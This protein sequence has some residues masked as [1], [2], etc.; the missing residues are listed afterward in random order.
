MMRLVVCFSFCSPREVPPVMPPGPTSH[1]LGVALLD[2]AAPR[3]T[4]AMSCD[5]RDSWYSLL[6]P[7]PLN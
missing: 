4:P 5:G 1:L 3:G 6:T 7:Q 2:M